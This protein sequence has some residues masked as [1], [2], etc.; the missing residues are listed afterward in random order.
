MPR[1]KSQ[2]TAPPENVELAR[3]NLDNEFLTHIKEPG[4]DPRRR[5]FDLALKAEDQE[6]Y[7]TAARCWAELAQYVSPKLRAIEVTG[8]VQ[9]T[10]VVF[11]IDLSDDEP[12]D[13]V[14]GLVT[15]KLG[16]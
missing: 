9:S 5:L 13:E 11:N 3:S 6:D 16:E 14:P 15:E 2:P 7:A 8:H 12:E 1:R 4:N 10:Q